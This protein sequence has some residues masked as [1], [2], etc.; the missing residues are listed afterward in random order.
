MKQIFY[1]KSLGKG[2]D[3]YNLADDDFV[4]VIQ[5]EFQKHML[6]QFGS[7]GLCCDSTHGTTGM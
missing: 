6:R 5:T 7:K 4:I 3:K 2:D 1:C